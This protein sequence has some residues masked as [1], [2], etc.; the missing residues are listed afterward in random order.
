[1][2]RDV[3]A[4]VVKG[5]APH[6]RRAS[7]RAE[8]PA[9]RGAAAPSIQAWL[10]SP[11]AVVLDVSRRL[12]GL[13]AEHE[14][15]SVFLSLVEEP[16]LLFEDPQWFD[17]G[18]HRPRHPQ[19]RRLADE[20]A[21]HRTRELAGPNDHDLAARRVAADVTDVDA[22]HHLGVPVQ[23]LH[24]AVAIR[25]WREVVGDVACLAANVGVQ[26]EV[27]LAALDEMARF[28]KCH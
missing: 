8:L 23:E 25:E 19:M 1:M 13:V 12:V 14:K 27:P 16:S 5:F 10:W 2:A 3:G 22:W 20:V 7:A 26:R 21:C 24:D 17:V 18:R 9:G 28:W 15:P 4:L 11:A 6:G